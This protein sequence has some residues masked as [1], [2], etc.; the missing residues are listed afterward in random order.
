MVTQYFSVVD[1]PL[2]ENKFTPKD[3]TPERMRV[4]A[5]EFVAKFKHAVETSNAEEFDALIVEGGYWRDVVAFTNDYRSLTKINVLQAAQDRLAIAGAYGGEVDMEPK[6]F[7]L[8]EYAY[9]EFGFNFATKLGPSTATVRLVRTSSGEVGAQ[10][11]YTELAGVH[12]YPERIRANR[13]HGDKNSAVPYEQLRQEEIDNPDPSVLIIGGGQCGLTVAARLKHLGVKALVVDR[14]E[15]IGDNWRKRYGSLALHDTLYGQQF[16]Y[17]KWPE[18][19]PEFINAGKLANW[20]EHYVE[21]LELNVW[22]KSHFDPE[23]SYFDE[24]DQK[25]HVTVVR[26]GVDYQFVVSHV[27]M[28]TGLSGGK[29]KWPAPLPGQDLFKKPIIHSA[30]HKGGA[31]LEGKKVLVIG[32]GSSGHDISLDLVNHGAHP[33]MLQRSPTFTMSI[34][35]GIIQTLNG[36][37][38]QDGVDLDYAD[39][40]ADTMPKAVAKSMHEKLIARIAEL[41]KDMIE[42]LKKAG[43]QWYPGPDGAGHVFLSMERG[44]GY[45]FDSGCCEKIINGQIKMQPGEIDHFTEDSVV[46]KDG[47]EM[48]PDLVIFCTGFTGFKESVAETLGPKHAVNLKKIWGLD[49]E[50]EINGLYRDCGIPKC[51]YMSGAIALA[52]AQSRVVAL[53]ILAEQLGQFGERYSIE[54]QKKTGTYVDLGPL[55]YQ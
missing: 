30:H 44:G 22:I 47:N 25:W 40:I 26:D 37:L 38:F 19:F 53:Q 20:L 46:F 9:I 1:A 17:M 36:D 8:D 6:F 18:T 13:I 50:G 28:A 48:T 23:R 39:R 55:V 49:A 2:P 45:Y 32:S 5:E 34:E 15:R 21:A 42:G 54:E 43:F 11:L 10:V 16:P 12:G 4:L 33:T 52:R 31:G 7:T 41:D 3:T 51:Y 29:A 24:K 35:K 14:F 27:V